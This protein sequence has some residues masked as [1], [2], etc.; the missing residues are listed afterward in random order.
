MDTGWRLITVLALALSAAEARAQSDSTT[1]KPAD[2]GLYL[3]GTLGRY[4]ESSEGKSGSAPAGSGI[5]GYR[6]GPW[7][8]QLEI[9]GT[10][11]SYCY[12][13]VEFVG[14]DGKRN[15]QHVDVPKKNAPPGSICHSDPVL[16]LDVIRRFGAGSARPYVAIGVGA[17]V[18]L[19]LG[20][21]VKVSERF[22]VAPAFDANAGAEFGSVRARLAFLFRF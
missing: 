3:G 13:Q 2:K 7:A 21:E 19:G 22:V 8:V 10:G 11:T 15:F 5:L 4:F 16:N 18:H 9:G 1:T 12:R 17:G 14:A 6:F 20:V